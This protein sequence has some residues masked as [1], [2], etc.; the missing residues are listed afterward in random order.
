[1]RFYSTM[2]WRR[3]TRKGEERGQWEV[4]VREEG[5]EYNTVEAIE[6]G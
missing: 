1:M 6:V 5:V 3:I 2:G 4:A